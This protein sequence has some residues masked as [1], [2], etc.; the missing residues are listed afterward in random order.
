MDL[1]QNHFKRDLKRRPPQIGSWLMAAS[2][3]TAEAMASAGFDWLV[4]DMEHAPFDMGA[5]FHC[6]QAIAGKP[7]SAVVRLPWNDTVMIK[8]VL[9]AGAQTLM[10]PMIQT[11]QEARQAVASLRYPPKG[12]RGV[13]AMTRAAQYGTAK[14]YFIGAESKLALILQLETP[15]ALSNLE[16]IAAIDGIDA[17]FVGPGDLSAAMGHIGQMNHRDLTT[18]LADAAGRANRIGMPIGIVGPTPERV[19]AFAEMGYDFLALSSDLGFMMAHA[20]N[21]L[22]ALRS[23]HTPIS[24]NSSGSY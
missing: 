2:P 23:T 19:K 11:A 20:Q 17:L 6:L 4:I 18:A 7:A 3:I 13:A 16:E 24:E 1:P 22:A 8:R 9:D 10:L 21:G 14:D 5:V 12:V 15:E